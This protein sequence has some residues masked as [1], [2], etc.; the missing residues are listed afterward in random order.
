[1]TEAEWLN[2]TD[3]EPMLRFLKGRASDRKLRLFAVACCR[4]NAHFVESWYRHLADVTERYA[5]GQATG[6]ELTAA[7]EA[8]DDPDWIPGRAF[9]SAAFCGPAD[10]IVAA[11]D[12][13]D[14]SAYAAADNTLRASQGSSPDSDPEVWSPDDENPAWIAANQAERAVQCALLRDIFGNPF[15]PIAAAPSQLTPAVI[16]MGIYNDRAFERMPELADALE[17][18]GCTERDLLEHCRGPGPHVRGCCV[19]DLILGKE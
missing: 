1:M 5:D 9:V 7:R 8:A 4:R 10:P 12:A 3:P 17:K 14:D 2:C 16:A 11:T 6:E 19:V 15:R 18:A 13:A